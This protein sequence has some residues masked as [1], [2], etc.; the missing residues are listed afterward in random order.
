MNI[1]AGG[2]AN[3]RSSY[4]L[5]LYMFRYGSSSGDDDDQRN[6]I[7]LLDTMPIPQVKEVRSKEFQQ[8]H[9]NGIKKK[10][11]E[12]LISN[13]EYGWK[14][15]KKRCDLLDELNG[16]SCNRR[17]LALVE[18]D[19]DTFED[20]TIEAAELKTLA[21]NAGLSDIRKQ[22]IPK[23]QEAG[24]SYDSLCQMGPNE[25]LSEAFESVLPLQSRALISFA[26]S[27]A[28]PMAWLQGSASYL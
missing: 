6:M 8:A 9:F 28:V 14:D 17:N 16:G 4:R 19:M 24:V 7:P 27:S 23:F 5:L 22:M 18:G 3:S 12:E 2:Q 25:F 20:E 15:F 11:L 10:R 1:C 13:E 26:F 21:I